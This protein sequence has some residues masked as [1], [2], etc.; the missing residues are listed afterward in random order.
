MFAPYYNN[1]KIFQFTACSWNTQPLV[2]D[3]LFFTW[4]FF[5]RIYIFVHI[6]AQ[7]WKYYTPEDRQKIFWMNLWRSVKS[8]IQRKQKR[9]KIKK[10]EGWRC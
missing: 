3:M 7:Q 1:N 10:S 5:L 6:K 4:L 9:N 8:L 2:S